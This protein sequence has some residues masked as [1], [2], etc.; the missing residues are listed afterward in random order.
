[1]VLAML[2][3]AIPEATTIPRVADLSFWLKLQNAEI[4]QLRCKS[5]G[6]DVP[7]LQ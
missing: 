7:S 2:P 3:H 4:R 6:M 5:G 1:M